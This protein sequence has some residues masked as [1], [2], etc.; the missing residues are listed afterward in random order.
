[1]QA[2]QLKRRQSFNIIAIT[3]WSQFAF[4]TFNAILI[5]YLTRPALAH[6]L[7][8]SQGRAYAFQGVSEAIKY[9]VLMLGGY[10]ADRYLGLRRAILYGSVLLA[11]AFLLIFL[12]GFLVRISNLFFVAA[13]ATIPVC[14][15]L[16]L[17]TS[18]AM[19]S[20][21]YSDNK[22][23]AKGAMTIFYMSINLGSIIAYFIAPSLIHFTYGPLVILAIVFVGK[24]ISALNFAWRYHLYDNVITETDRKP[25]TL[26]VKV[27]L[28]FYF[29]SIYLITL[30]AYNFPNMASWILGVFCL[31]CLTAF[32]VR[33]CTL[34][35]TLRV[36]QIVAV[37][38]ILMA[39]IF[40]V[41]Y[42]QMNST[43]ILL[44]HHNSSLTLLGISVNAANYQMIN[45]IIIIIGGY[46]FSHVYRRF[47]R[48]NIPYQFA[49][50][51]LLS[52]F[53]LLSIWFG[54][55]FADTGIINGN[56]IALSY[57]LISVSELFV[58][59]IGLSMIGLYCDMR[60]IAFAMGAWYIA[61]S[62]SYVLSGQINQLVALPENISDRLKSAAIYQSYFLHLGLV[63]LIL[64]L[65]FIFVAY[66]VTRYL[67]SHRIEVV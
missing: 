26:G 61:M 36:K 32:M 33:T 24:S 14:T 4:Y 30:I 59:A 25:L 22:S 21:I 62:F 65:V 53:G 8:F 9:A 50:G 20:K 10:M 15:S 67:K 42:N 43:L 47:P 41:V 46:L 49:V 13:Y 54:F 52:S 16:L 37:I 12:S 63:V 31:I 7:G 38:L 58:M 51:T 35:F 28:L 56:F 18:S 34:T 5:L 6:G 48:F 64:S 44:A 66:G 55:L 19:I 60:M 1:M 11:I 45:P 17:G 39:V 27:L 40:S 23:Q 3:F 2:S 57:I 29:I